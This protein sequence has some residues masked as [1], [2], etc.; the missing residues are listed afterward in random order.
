MDE[1]HPTV[2]RPWGSF[3]VLEEG[4]RYKVKRLVVHPG[5]KLSLQ[6]HR[7]R[8]EHWVVIEGT[9]KVTN[10]EKEFLLKENEAAFISQGTKHRLENPGTGPLAIIEVQVGSYLGEDDIQRFDDLYGRTPNSEKT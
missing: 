7:Q 3:T 5:Q 4:P 1:S 10:G 2:A 6:S 9:A 8:A